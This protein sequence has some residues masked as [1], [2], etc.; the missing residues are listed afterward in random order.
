MKSM[1]PVWRMTGTNPDKAYNDRIVYLPDIQPNAVFLSSGMDIYAYQTPHTREAKT[2]KVIC[3]YCMGSGNEIDW[4]DEDCLPIDG[5]T[6]QS[7]EGNG[8]YFEIMDGVKR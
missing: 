1:K 4:S 8:H 2:F 3:A 5:T 6:C 7:C